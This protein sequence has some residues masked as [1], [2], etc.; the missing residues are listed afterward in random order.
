[1][2]TN[3]RKAWMN[4]QIFTES[5]D[6]N[7]IPGVKKHQKEIGKSGKVLLVL[8]NAPSHPNAE[9]LEHENGMFKVIFLPL[10][11]TSL[12]QPMDQSVTETVKRLCRKQLLKKILLD[13]VEHSTTMQIDL[14][15]C[16]MMSANG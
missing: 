14:K 7:F 11:V 4:C 1:M 12:L 8:D 9:I 15:E 16:F 13:E 10:N 5:Y 6:N 2:Y 3:Q